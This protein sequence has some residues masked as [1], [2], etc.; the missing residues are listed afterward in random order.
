[1]PANGVL[2]IAISTDISGPHH[3]Q[4]LAASAESL[5]LRLLVIESGVLNPPVLPK[6]RNPARPSETWAGR[7]SQPRWLSDQLRHGKKLNDFRIR[8]H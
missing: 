3:A 5:E 2:R 8:A 7:G 4:T 6:F 1:M